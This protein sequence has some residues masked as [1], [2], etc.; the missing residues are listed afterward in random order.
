VISTN[1][2]FCLL[3][4][5]DGLLLLSTTDIRLATGAFLSASHQAFP[6]TP[7]TAN[8][9]AMAQSPLWWGDYVSFLAFLAICGG[10]V[11]LMILIPAQAEKLQSF[12][13][14]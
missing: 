12:V 3:D 14:R 6:R 8:R 10:I 9:F 1:L 7:L 4:P 11:Y 5:Q 2:D 13:P